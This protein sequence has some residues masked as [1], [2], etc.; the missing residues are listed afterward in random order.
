MSHF[1][2]VAVSPRF[3]LV[4]DTGTP[5]GQNASTRAHRYPFASCDEISLIGVKIIAWKQNH[6][7]DNDGAPQSLVAL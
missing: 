6:L 5:G 1:D 2:S 3:Y 7:I 4:A